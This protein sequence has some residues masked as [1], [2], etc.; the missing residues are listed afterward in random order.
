MKSGPWVS[1]LRGAISTSSP[2]LPS[3]P[4]AVGAPRAPPPRGFGETLLSLSIGIGFPENGY[5][6]RLTLYCGRIYEIRREMPSSPCALPPPPSPPA[7]HRSL[8]L[9]SGRCYRHRAIRRF[10]MWTCWI[11]RIA[12]T[13]PP[14]PPAPNPRLQP[15]WL[16]FASR[17]FYKSPTRARC[18]ILFSPDRGSPLATHAPRPG[19]YGARSPIAGDQSRRPRG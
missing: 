16:V 5:S 12:L 6:A 1:Y 7:F 13:P 2:Y 9:F 8:G 15:P 19:T 3:V 18:R 11:Y 10:N 17:F 4:G 14:P